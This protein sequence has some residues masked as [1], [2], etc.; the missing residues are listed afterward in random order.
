[1]DHFSFGPLKTDGNA[2]S[3]RWPSKSILNDLQLKS[4]PKLV[5]IRTA[6]RRNHCLGAIQLVFADGLESPL[7][8][9][10]CSNP[11]PLHTYKVDKIVPEQ[12]IVK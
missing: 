11:G 6:E 3:F 2:V 1:M 9:A 5:A 4:L 12:I 7:F 8:E 10:K